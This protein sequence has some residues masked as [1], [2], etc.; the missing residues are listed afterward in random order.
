MDMK[1]QILDIAQRLIQQRGVNGFSYADI[2]KE[3]S[4][5]KPSLHHHFATKADLVARLMERYTDQLVQYLG[6]A[7]QA[8]SAE[9]KLKTYIDLYRF[10]LDQRRICMGGMLS[11]ESLTL[12]SS[13][14][15]QI[16][17]FFDLQYQW[18]LK[19]LQQ[20]ISTGELQLT[21]A[22]E[23][24]ASMILATL[25]GALVISR[26]SGDTTLFDDSAKGIL[27]SLK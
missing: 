5:S 17:R 13:I 18:L 20:G 12:D 23:A 2:A 7:E 8:N 6:N 26:T 24:Y 11:A 10:S 4:V 1:E 3:L 19:V 16:R 9:Q 14:H 21:K 15:P 25:Q 27:A 22:P